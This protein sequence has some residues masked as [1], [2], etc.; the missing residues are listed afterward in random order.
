MKCY[1]HRGEDAVGVCKS[2]QKALCAECA[3]DLGKGIACRDRCEEDVKQL[4]A[5]VDASIRYSPAS[6]SLV[7]AAKR[8][9]MLSAG[10]LVAMG[11]VFLWW[12]MTT[13][14]GLGFSTVFGGGFVLYGVL[15]L[16]RMSRLTT[17][18]VE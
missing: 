15:Q 6:R 7:G 11:A 13:D 1:S 10:F 18:R 3:V 12:G 2:C 8:T 17:P 4:I 9:G 5:I 14:E 16:I